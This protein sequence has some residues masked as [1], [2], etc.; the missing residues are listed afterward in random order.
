MAGPVP[1]SG[2]IVR[3][4]VVTWYAGQ[5]GLNVM[6]WEVV[7]RTGG[8]ATL[9]EIVDDLDGI[10]ST[11]YKAILSASAL[12][13]GM[14]AQ[15][16]SP[17]IT[18]EYRS[19]AGAGAGGVSGDPM[20]RQVSGLVSIRSPLGGARNR[21]RFYPPFP[22]ESDN[23]AGGVISATYITT[24]TNLMNVLF[25]TVLVVGAG[26]TAEIRLGVYHR[27]TATVTP[28]DSFIVS[29][30]WATQRRRGSLG[31]PNILPF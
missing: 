1:L 12:Y 11:P 31:R 21:G 28:A 6:H 10:F 5:V 8:G 14:T 7:N 2:D 18:I 25:P 16:V 24:L 9:Q 30:V 3:T 27:N 19:I 22:G 20:P 4:R 13:R 26:G 17:P 23:T 15:N 29:P